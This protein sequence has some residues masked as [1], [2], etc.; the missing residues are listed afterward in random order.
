CAPRCWPPSARASRRSC[1]PRRTPPTSRATRASSASSSPRSTRPSRPCSNRVEARPAL[2]RSSR[3]MSRSS[4][5]NEP[6]LLDPERDLRLAEDARAFLKSPG[7]WSSAEGSLLAWLVAQDAAL[8][9][10][11]V[12]IDTKDP[13]LLAAT[14]ELAEDSARGDDVAFQV[15][16]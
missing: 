14:L 7:D 8:L 10:L 13:A 1:S 3:R 6:P 11:E 12:A 9:A 5:P 15:P 2:G 16:E 4:L